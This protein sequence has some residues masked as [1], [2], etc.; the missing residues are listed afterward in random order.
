MDRLKKE[1]MASGDSLED[2][3]ADKNALAEFGGIL[4]GLG[5]N[6]GEVE[7]MVSELSSQALENEVT[8]ADLFQVASQLTA[9]DEG[10][11]VAV[12]LDAS[13]LPDLEIILGQ[14]GL[15]HKTGRELLS[16]AFV[17]GKGIDLEVLASG[18]RSAMGEL[19]TESET[20]IGNPAEVLE[21]MRRIGLPADGETAYQKT[22]DE[23]ISEV[24]RW[25]D[26]GTFAEEGSEAGGIP[27][28]LLLSYLQQLVDPLEDGGSQLR[29]LIASAGDEDGGVDGRTLLSK[30][31]QLKQEASTGVGSGMTAGTRSAASDSGSISLERF[32]AIL[33]DRIAT[34]DGLR[35][36]ANAL[37]GSRSMADIA[38]GFM[39][40]VV[41]AAEGTSEGRALPVDLEGG[42]PFQTPWQPG[43]K[44]FSKSDNRLSTTR[45]AS[46]TVAKNGTGESGALASKQTVSAEGAQRQTAL[47]P[48]GVN[49]AEKFSEVLNAA[50]RDKTNNTGEDPGLGTEGLAREMKAGDG[51]AS[52]G[53]TAAGRNLPGYLLNQVS[54]QILR[55]RNAGENELTLQLKPP[56]LGRMKLNIEHASGGIRVGIV[57]ESSAARDML[58]ANSHDLKAALADQGLRLD[59][60]DV[61]AQADFGQS[62]AQAG[63]GFGQSGGRKS[64]WTAQR[65]ADAEGVSESPAAMDP[66]TEG[67]E[68]GRLDLVA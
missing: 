51:T 29:R 64:R 46:E 58:L 36:G 48:S 15:D 4:V 31:M 8:L 32:V 16:N 26:T 59:K 52:F 5:F 20:A 14:L 22:L 38:R 33:E 17:E 2:Y 1:I 45:S 9:P 65:Q 56:H 47:N 61:E 68:P 55:L 23:L 24:T 37:H 44:R 60:I 42:E 25:S 35:G 21:R 62:M 3:A 39:E 49:S 7:E 34:A 18:I 40:N 10:S 6:A 50:G 67:T 41:A 30:L 53:K 27:G 13:A 11:S 57:V 12:M 28:S 63:R 54:R 43:A 66:G 19:S